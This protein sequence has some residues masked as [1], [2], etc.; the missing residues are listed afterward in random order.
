MM[1]EKMIEP[2]RQLVDLVAA[3]CLG[4]SVD[5]LPDEDSVGWN[6]DGELPMTFGHVRRAQAAI[7]A[8]E[9]FLQSQ[10]PA[11]K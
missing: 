7:G 4:P 10:S 9:A 5:S 3:E 6:G 1:D 8:L 2:L 11:A